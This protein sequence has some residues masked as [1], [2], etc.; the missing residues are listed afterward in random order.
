M[1]ELF[2]GSGCTTPP[3]TITL[4]SVGSMETAFFNNYGDS[5]E[6]SIYNNTTE[7][8]MIPSLINTTIQYATG[9]LVCIRCLYYYNGVSEEAAIRYFKIWL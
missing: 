5:I 7:T 3:Y 2:E 8:I 4:P 9:E 1:V 6:F